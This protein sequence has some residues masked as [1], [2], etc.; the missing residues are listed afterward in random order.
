M[1]QSKRDLVELHSPQICHE[2]L[3]IERDVLSLEPTKTIKAMF[4]SWLRSQV[5][6]ILEILLVFLVFPLWSNPEEI[7]QEA[8]AYYQQGERATTY[9]ERKR[10]FNQSLSLYHLVAQELDSHFPALERAIGDNYFQLNEYAWAI[11]HYQ[12]ALKAAPHDDLLIS[13]LEKAQ[14]KLGITPQSSFTPQQNFLSH[15]LL[16]FSEQ[17]KLLYWIF[18]ISFMIC[19]VAIWVPYSWIRKL[20]ASCVLLLFLILSNFLFFHYFTPLEGILVTPTGFYRSPDW[21]QPQLTNYPLLAGSKVR[22]LQV[23]SEGN[24]LKITNS[25]GLVGY[26]PTSTLRII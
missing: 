20:A 25:T 12:R 1:T 8:N 21:G 7:L 11:L 14:E 26:I 17:F 18:L 22:V 3:G 23:V 2:R 4:L 24:W 5:F 13:H 6:F 16:A 9:E 10:S 19:S 15:I